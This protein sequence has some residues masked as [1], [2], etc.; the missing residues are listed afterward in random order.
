MAVDQ[1]TDGSDIGPTTCWGALTKGHTV[2]CEPGF[3]IGKAHFKNKFCTHCRERIDMPLNKIRAMTPA[4]RDA[5]TNP[6]SEGFWKRAPP[7]LGGGAFR[8]V[9]N[10][11]SCIGPCLIIYQTGVPEL[12]NGL[13]F[14]P[15]PEGWA[16]GDAVPLAVAKGTLVPVLQM[17]KSQE[18]EARNRPK[19]RRQE[20]AG[21]G[22]PDVADEALP[23]VASGNFVGQLV[24]MHKQLEALLA[25]LAEKTRLALAHLFACVT[26]VLEEV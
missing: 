13:E 5:Y 23:V 8:L 2:G 10:T 6:L 21:V 19:R 17:W 4:L 25:A 20:K 18:E 14:A 26:S 3:C 24:G 16:L 12:P 1:P 22:S 7:T 9:N 15:M 11:Q